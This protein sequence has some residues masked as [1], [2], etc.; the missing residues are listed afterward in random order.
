MFW[1]YVW[2]V[3]V[4]TP[5]CFAIFYFLIGMFLNRAKEKL[6]E[7]EKELENRLAPLIR[8]YKKVIDEADSKEVKVRKILKEIVEST[9]MDQI[10][11]K[12]NELTEIP[13]RIKEVRRKGKILTMLHV[14]L[15]L[16]C[17]GMIALWVGIPAGPSYPKEAELPEPYY[18]NI[19]KYG[20]GSLEDLKDLLDHFCWTR[21][22]EA[23]VFDCSEMSA[24]M[25]WYLENHGFDTIIATNYTE[26]HAWVVVR[27]LKSENGNYR[28]Y[29]IE[30]ITPKPQIRYQGQRMDFYDYPDRI[31]NDIYEAE[32]SEYPWEYDWWNA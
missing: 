29:P 23:G 17:V 12:I 21:S 3:F 19:H 18:T 9:P 15:S 22:N 26:H 27:H 2:P 28:D 10:S 4:F 7:Q 6:R 13:A 31:F 25:E 11:T 20:T 8:S 5:L 24:Y 30:V 1:I 14:F 32:A 16:A